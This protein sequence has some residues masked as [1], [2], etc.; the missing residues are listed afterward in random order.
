M[1]EVIKAPQ[2]PLHARNPL[3]WSIAFLLAGLAWILTLEQTLGMRSMPM[4]GTHGDD[5][6]SLFILL[7]D[8]GCNGA[9]PLAPLD[10]LIYK[11]RMV[12]CV[13]GPYRYRLQQADLVEM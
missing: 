2:F 5:T 3:A 7:G 1:S 11:G 13:G 8:N 6:A 4:Y 9:S 12:E 10:W